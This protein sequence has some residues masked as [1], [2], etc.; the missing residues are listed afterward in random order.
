[1]DKVFAKINRC[2][3]YRPFVVQIILAAKL[4]IGQNINIEE[5]SKR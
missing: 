5:H 2:G 1:M 3:M 4:N